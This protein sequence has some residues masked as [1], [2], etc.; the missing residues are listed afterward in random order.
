[1]QKVCIECKNSVLQ[2]KGEIDFYNVVSLWQQGLI[3][4]NDL[5]SV[6]VD[7]KQVLESDSSGLALLTAW[8][9]A[10]REKNKKIVLINIPNFMRDILRVYGLEDVLP[11][12]WE[13]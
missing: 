3:F 13:N 6:K 5:E 1:M 7:L 8:V 12:L 11:V 9:R 4:I 10:A 2:L